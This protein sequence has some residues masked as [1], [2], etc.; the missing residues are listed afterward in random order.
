MIIRER[1]SKYEAICFINIFQHAILRWVNKREECD[2]L[3]L[4][5]REAHQPLAAK[6]FHNMYLNILKPKIILSQKKS[7]MK[8][9]HTTF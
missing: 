2:W 1:S 5:M 9:T 6:S 3:H 4:S 8:E 7:R